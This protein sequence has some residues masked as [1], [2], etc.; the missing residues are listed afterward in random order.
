MIEELP[1][2]ASGYDDE[3]VEDRLTQ[4][5]YD[6]VQDHGPLDAALAARCAVAPEDFEPV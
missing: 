1:A 4:K 5:H 2:A 6:I 3:D